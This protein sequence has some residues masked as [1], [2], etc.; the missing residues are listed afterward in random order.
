[1]MA[2]QILMEKKYFM[3]FKVVGCFEHMV[4]DGILKFGAVTDWLHLCSENIVCKTETQLVLS[5]SFLVSFH[6]GKDLGP[7]KLSTNP[8]CC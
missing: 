4:E 3:I 2:N 6:W 5:Y 7:D 1:M 8:M